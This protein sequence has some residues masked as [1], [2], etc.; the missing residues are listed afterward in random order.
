MLYHLVCPSGYRLARTGFE[1][2]DAVPMSADANDS[3]SCGTPRQTPS[4][5]VDPRIPLNSGLLLEL[6]SAVYYAMLVNVLFCF[7]YFINM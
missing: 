7:L 1:E 2:L 5:V 4:L 6:L 3:W